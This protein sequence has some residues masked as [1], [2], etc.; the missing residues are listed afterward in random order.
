MKSKILIISAMVIS[1]V[2][3]NAVLRADIN[4]ALGTQCY[5]ESSDFHV[6]K[7]TASKSFELGIPQCPTNLSDIDTDDIRHCYLGSNRYVYT[8]C[9]TDVSDSET[10]G[11]ACEEIIQ[12]YSEWTSFGNNRV[13]RSYTYGAGLDTDAWSANLDI[14]TETEYGC[15]TSYYSTGGSGA[16]ITCALCPTPGTSDIGTTNITECYIPMGTAFSDTTGNGTYI[17]DCHYKK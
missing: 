3:A 4:S 6:G 9:S 10:N 7:C 8:I 16:S 12:P 17:N 11:T 1:P 2:A 15:D 14:F 13:S 5:S